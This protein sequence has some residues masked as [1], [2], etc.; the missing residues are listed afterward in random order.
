MSLIKKLNFDF[1][2]DKVNGYYFMP[3]SENYLNSLYEKGITRQKV[4]LAEGDFL[5]PIHE[6]I[7]ITSTLGPRWGKFHAGLDISA[8]KGTIIVAYGRKGCK[9]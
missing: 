5:W 4:A 1:S 3:Y 7:K 8:A 6:N 9:I 2:L